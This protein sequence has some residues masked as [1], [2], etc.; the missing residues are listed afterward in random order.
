MA[1]NWP[2]SD[3]GVCRQN[4]DDSVDLCDYV[5][6]NES[7]QPDDKNESSFR[8]NPDPF[9]YFHYPHYFTKCSV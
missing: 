1:N 3:I 8:C 6:A 7:C 9:Y 5:C 4:G 2:F